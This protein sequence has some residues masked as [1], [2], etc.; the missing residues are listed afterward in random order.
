[1]LDQGEPGCCK[2]RWSFV[3]IS[4]FLLH[5]F[6][7]AVFSRD[8][9]ARENRQLRVRRLPNRNFA[10]LG[11]IFKLSQQHRKVSPISVRS[12]TSIYE[13]KNQG[14]FP[15]QRPTER[16]RVMSFHQTYRN[17]SAPVNSSSSSYS[18]HSSLY[19]KPANY[20]S[21]VRSVSPLPPSNQQSESPT[22]QIYSPTPLAA[23]TSN[24]SR[25]G[26]SP[27]ITPDVP[28]PARRD[29]SP[30]RPLYASSIPTTLSQKLPTSQPQPQLTQPLTNSAAYDPSKLKPLYTNEIDDALRLC[31]R[32]QNTAVNEHGKR[33]FAALLLGPDNVS[34]LASH[35]SISHYQHAESE[36]ARLVA[37]Q[38]QRTYLEKCTLVSTWEPC[39]MCSGTIYW[40]GI[41]RVLY[42]ASETKLKELTGEGNTE[43]MTMNVPCRTILQAGQR[44]V[45]VTGP[46]VSWE[47]TVVE[48][49]GKWWREHQ[50]GIVTNGAVVNGFSRSTSSIGARAAADNMSVASKRT[51]ITI[52]NPDESLL[53]SIGEDGE[54]QADLKI[55][56]MP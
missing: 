41:G 53:G 8:T 4:L 10:I 49:A 28:P 30:D 23:L 25:P 46:V 15:S 21:S 56:W 48:E 51:S 42:A 6:P 13:E 34:V 43:N 26:I 17:V 19:R 9:N 27:S 31:L 3:G 20:S 44:Q 29:P 5:A 32:M 36:L 52:Y 7:D 47:N 40:T 33:P 50:A 2:L 54:Y 1:M 22:N 24:P 14:P 38:Y 11:E 18:P 16:G 37:L 45:E 55:D 35:N 39:A 12:L